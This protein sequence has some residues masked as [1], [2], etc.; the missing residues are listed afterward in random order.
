MTIILQSKDIPVDTAG[1]PLLFITNCVVKLLLRYLLTSNMKL[2][3]AASE[4]LY[5]V[6]NTKEGKRLIGNCKKLF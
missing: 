6:M 2:A 4:T 1:A 3:R 5:N